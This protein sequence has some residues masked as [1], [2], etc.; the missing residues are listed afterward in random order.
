MSNMFDWYDKVD[1]FKIKKMAGFTQAYA[2]AIKEEVESIIRL[3]KSKDIPLGL[4]L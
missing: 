1:V 2:E 3:A 4:D